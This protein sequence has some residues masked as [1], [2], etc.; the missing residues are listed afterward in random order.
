MFLLIVKY[1]TTALIIVAVSEV[2]KH[3]GRLGALIASLPLV[4]I[5]VMIWLQ[6]EGQSREKIANHAWFTFWYVIPTLP[7]FA[8]MPWLLHRGWNFWSALLAAVLLTIGCFL[9]MVAAAQRLG[10]HLMP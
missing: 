5:M 9:G 7:M 1:A 8:L 2:A 6:I 4:T 10:V 3:S